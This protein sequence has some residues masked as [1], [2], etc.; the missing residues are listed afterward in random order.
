MDRPKDRREPKRF[1]PPPWERDRFEEIERKRADELD[2]ERR[3]REA[4]LGL[5]ATE[6]AAEPAGQEA[7]PAGE[8]ES[9]EVAVPVSDREPVPAPTDGTAPS[10]TKAAQL[11]AM[12]IGLSA[13]ERDTFGGDS[14]A[15]GMG[16]AA[17]LG[18]V[19][20][21]MLAYAV[22]ALVRTGG[23]GGEAGTLALAGAGVVG[24]FGLV[25]MGSAAWLGMRTYGNRGVGRWL[26]IPSRGSSPSTS[27][28]S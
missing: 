26:K 9:A 1:E 16:A 17:L 27:R 5:A 7:P 11:D 6:E 18:F 22:V 14:F 12:I 15:W 25:I 2:E 19:G 24:F 28:R 21:V 13:E 20:T 23:A 10:G 4:L 3:A 8:A